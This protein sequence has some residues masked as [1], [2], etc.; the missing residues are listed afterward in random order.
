MKIFFFMLTL[1]FVILFITNISWLIINLYL[2]STEGIATIISEENGVLFENI[3]YSDYVKWII[4]ADLGWVVSLFVFMF[5]R[6]HYKTEP[7]LHYL[8]SDN[9]SNPK[10]CVTIP[11]YN[12][13]QAIGEVV[14]DYKNQKFVESI[15]VIDNNSSDKTVEIAKQHGATVVA[16][17]ENKG[18]SHSYVLGL[19]ESLKTDANIIV[20]TEGDGTYSAD[21]LSK[22][23]PYLENCDMV[24]GSRQNQILTE[25]G[26]QNSRFIVWGNVFLGK[27][28]QLKH[29]SLH[30]L[31]I[32][33][34]TDVGCVFT[35]IKRDG[36]LKI[37]EQLS[38]VETE[39][40]T[41]NVSLRLYTTL[42][43]IENDLR[44]IEIPIT[45]KK[46]IGDS[47]IGTGKK[48]QAIKIGL[49]FLWII[50]RY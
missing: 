5:T 38:K 42:L 11:S 34:L 3:Y 1:I 10:I 4:W 26:N 25:K 47:K 44:L 43:A 15:I 28:I 12:E 40:S 32:V 8:Q 30:H 16:K 46:R 13:E 41:W 45:F 7:S 37:I 17:K 20:V 36:L 49:L 18:F 19:K 35:I 22:L 9:I 24:S 6:K 23:L 33:N 50:L 39:K 14:T 2:W 48:L 31:G 21:D 27:L 29:F